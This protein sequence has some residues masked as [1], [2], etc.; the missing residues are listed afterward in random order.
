[1]DSKVSI[2]IVNFNGK[3]Y[4]RSCI[5]SILKNNYFNY[6]II[7]VDNDSSDGSLEMLKS[8][9]GEI[10]KVKV[11]KLDKN[12]GPAFARNQGVKAAQGNIVS[13]LDN[14]TEV[15]A[16]WIKNAIKYF[17]ND[18][19]VGILQ[20]KL[21]MLENKTRLD[22]AGEYLGS[23]GFLIH[24]AVFNEED[25]GQYD[26]P[27]EL[28]AAKSAGMFIRKDVFNKIGGFDQDY[29]IFVEETD[30]GWR[31]WLAGYKVIFG[32]DSRV[33][34]HFSVTK[35][36][37]DPSFNNYL[38]RFHG[39]KNYAL[40][41]YKN[42]SLKSLILILPRHILLWLG[43]AGYLFLKGNFLSA[44][45]ITK[46]LWWNIANYQAN[47]NKRRQV[48]KNRVIT[49]RDLFK[50][51]YRKIGIFYYIKKFLIA[52]KQLVTPENQ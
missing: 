35:K 49:D 43:L 9:Y 34:H 30:L 41:L 25:M 28:L 15:D 18:P 13:F 45:N 23:L 26:Q 19:T 32:F 24:R 12:Y 16:D 2:V 46:G 33:Y 5:S 44:C 39:T 17:A 1:M 7:V 21:L 48:Q 20:C 40:T 38:V 36:I 47:R 51:V 29:F 8:E 50:K 31:T 52:Q 14:D 37:V 3:N 4:L 10:S 42:L 22:Y 27:D 11:V 6:E